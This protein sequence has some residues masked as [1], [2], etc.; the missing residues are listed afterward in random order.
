MT[1]PAPF[2][3]MEIVDEVPVQIEEFCT[4]QKACLFVEQ[5]VPATRI[6]NCSIL[7]VKIEKV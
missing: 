4:Y 3:V 7:E 2:K 6:P 1:F 5:I